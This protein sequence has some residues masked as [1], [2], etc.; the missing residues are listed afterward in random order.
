MSGGVEQRLRGAAD[1]QLERGIDA[2][3][4]ELAQLVRP[5]DHQSHRDTLDEFGQ[6]AVRLAHL[7]LVGHVDDYA[8]GSDRYSVSVDHDADAVADMAQR[9]VGVGDPIRQFVVSALVDC[10]LGLTH[11]FGPVECREP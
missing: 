4:R 3:R 6:V 10:I 7:H 2:D 11:D 9:S 8:A 1:Q 5:C